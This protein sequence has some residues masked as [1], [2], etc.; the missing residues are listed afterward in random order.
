M[1]KSTKALLYTFASII[2]TVHIHI[3]VS[4]MSGSEGTKDMSKLTQAAEEL[5][6]AASSHVETTSLALSRDAVQELKQILQTSTSQESTLKSLEESISSLEKKLSE[7]RTHILSMNKEI[8]TI[9]QSIKLQTKRQSLDW[10]STNADIS[11]FQYCS[12]CNIG[13]SQ[14]YKKSTELVRSIL[15]FFRK[16]TGTYIDGYS[17][18][19]A[20]G[21]EKDSEGVEFRAAIANQLEDLLG[22]K[23]RVVSHD[24]KW[25][26]YYE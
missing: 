25:A 21:G 20:L 8:M 1:K 2:H 18:I 12:S 26:I 17:K 9:N 3:F 10:A 11:S 4:K 19:T 5:I 15:T 14:R 7:M 13:Y 16:G 6:K 22:T 24:G 23:P